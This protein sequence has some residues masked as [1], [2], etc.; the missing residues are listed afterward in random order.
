MEEGQVV[1]HSN[2]WLGMAHVTRMPCCWRRDNNREMY[3]FEV[4]ETKI[5][6]GWRA[7]RWNETCQNGEGLPS[8]GKGYVPFRTPD[9][10]HVNAHSLSA[11]SLSYGSDIKEW[12]MRWHWQANSTYKFSSRPPS[13]SMSH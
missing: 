3:S 10:C 1:H 4:A 5:A 7:Q 9:T 2:P 8:C 6:M 11:L 13:W 12:R